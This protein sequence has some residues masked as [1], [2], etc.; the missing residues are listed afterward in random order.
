MRKTSKRLADGR[1]IIYYD[2]L[3][4]PERQAEDR[5]P[6]DP[7]EVSSELRYDP[8]LGTWVMFASHRQDRT[9]LPATE[10][11]PLCPT[12]PGHLTEIPESDYQVAVFE[13]RFPALSAPPRRRPPPARR[14]HRRGR[15][16]PRLRR[17]GQ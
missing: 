11:C 15:P 3:P 6:L 5:R 13:N 16:Q 4:A 7:L 10:D 17:G 8:L 14:R 2:R 9:Y 1:Q 12:S